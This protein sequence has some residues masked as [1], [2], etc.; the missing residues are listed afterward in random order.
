MGLNRVSVSFAALPSIHTAVVTVLETPEQA[1][2][3]LVM[4]QIEYV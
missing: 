2:A 1:A 3:K 4:E